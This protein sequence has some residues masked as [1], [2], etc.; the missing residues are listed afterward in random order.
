MWQRKEGYYWVK[1]SGVWMIALWIPELL[2]WYFAANDHCF[3][4]SELDFISDE[5]IK[6]PDDGNSNE[7]VK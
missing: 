6:T 2:W 1:Y 3:D 4:D 7:T 5:P